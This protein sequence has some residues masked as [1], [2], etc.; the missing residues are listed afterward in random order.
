MPFLKID[1]DLN[2][3]LKINY[4]MVLGEIFITYALLTKKQQKLNFKII[5]YPSHYKTE[6]H[7]AC[8]LF[9]LETFPLEQV[10]E[11]FEKEGGIT[12][13]NVE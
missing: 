4:N 8:L 5:K 13:L 1:L 7:L 12:L 10:L 11:R 3:F 9:D 6:D 2:Q